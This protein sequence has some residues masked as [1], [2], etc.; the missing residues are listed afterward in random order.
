MLRKK[1]FTLLELIIVI[2]VIGILASIALPRYTNVVN[3][4]KLATAQ[5]T[6]GE[7]RKAQIAYAANYGVYCNNSDIDDLDIAYP[8]TGMF[9]F[10]LPTST[11]VTTG[12]DDVAIATGDG[13]SL[14]TGSAGCDVTMTVD[15]NFNATSTLCAAW[16]LEALGL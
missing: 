8:L 10:S 3:K 1:G 4:A 14:A 13:A 7:F 5:Q 12:D 2:I 9:S 11:V 6:L 16:V 15:G